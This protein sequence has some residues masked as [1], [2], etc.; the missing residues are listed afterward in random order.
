MLGK[1][2]KYEFKAS[3]KQFLPLA[4]IYLLAAAVMRLGSVISQHTASVVGIIFALFSFIFGILSIGVSL[5]PIYNAVSRFSKNILGSEGYLMNTL[6]V[7]AR[8]HIISKIIVV[9]TMNIASVIIIFLS[10][11]VMFVGDKTV[12]ELKE[13]FSPLYNM[14]KNA[15]KNHPL[16]FIEVVV[17]MI[18]VSVMISLMLYSAISLG[19]LSNSGRKGKGI[20]FIAGFIFIQILSYIFIIMGL[21]KCSAFTDWMNKLGDAQQNEMI[22]LIT[23]IYALIFSAIHYIITI[24]VVTKKL[25]LQ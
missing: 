13:A 24:K 16:L 9:F 18:I 11:V 5:F 10:N 4:A 23:I 14:I 25:N 6:P 19:H 8:N 20:A 17:C 7:K 21:D 3:Y 12:K 22:G 2:L 1:L 15:I